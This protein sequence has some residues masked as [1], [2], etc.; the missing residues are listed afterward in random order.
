MHQ[1][2][3]NPFLHNELMRRHF[4]KLTFAKIRNYHT[5]LLYIC[6]NAGYSRYMIPFW[7]GVIVYLLIYNMRKKFCQ[8]ISTF[9]SGLL[10]SRFLLKSPRCM[11]TLSKW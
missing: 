3:E 9:S 6:T 5:D 2:H 4:H 10:Q 7:P 1:E 8:G 11:S